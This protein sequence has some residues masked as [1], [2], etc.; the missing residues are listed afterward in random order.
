VVDGLGMIDMRMI[1]TAGDGVAH[2]VAV[3]GG[4]SVFFDVIV[5]N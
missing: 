5:Q 2:T 4:L 1:M 3:Q